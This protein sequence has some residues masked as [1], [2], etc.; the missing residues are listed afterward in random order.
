MNMMTNDIRRRNDEMNMMTNAIRRLCCVKY[1][2]KDCVLGF[3]DSEIGIPCLY[4][5]HKVGDKDY[6][7]VYQRLIR[8]KDKL[9]DDPEAFKFI[10]SKYSARLE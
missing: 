10:V 6:T 1:N 8:N 7:E 4:I 3:S 9:N 2:C 5:E